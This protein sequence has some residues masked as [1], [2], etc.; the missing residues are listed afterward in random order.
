MRAIHEFSHGDQHQNRI[1]AIGELVLAQDHAKDHPDLAGKIRNVRRYLQ[2]RQYDQ[3]S[4][5]LWNDICTGLDVRIAAELADSERSAVPVQITPVS[6]G[7]IYIFSN[8]KY[9]E[10]NKISPASNDLLVFLNKASTIDYYP[11]HRQKI[12]Y[13]RSPK[14]EL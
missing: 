1:Y 5:E 6:V 13:H 14:E 7:K 4:P 10:E 8:V 9:P 11:D 2:Y 12:V 3:I